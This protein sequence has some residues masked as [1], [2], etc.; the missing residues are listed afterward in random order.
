MNFEIITCDTASPIPVVV[1]VP[2]SSTIIPPDVRQMLCLDDHALQRELLCLTDWFTDRIFDPVLE[3]GGTLFVNRVSR[4]VVDPERFPDDSQEVMA[5]KGMGAVYTHT[6]DGRALRTL[7]VPEERTRLLETYF[8]PYA[9]AFAEL[10]S[11]MLDRHGRCVILDGHSFPSVPLPYERDQ[12]IERP[13]I[14]LGTDDF[15]TPES[16]VAAIRD[17]CAAQGFHV[18]QNRPFAGTY[19]PFRYWQVDP[20]VHS[21]MMEI[22]RDLYM[23]EQTG[24]D[25]PGLSGIR[26]LV[27]SVMRMMGQAYKPGGPSDK[28]L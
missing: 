6:A 9:N 1:H 8:H 7:S 24:A 27:L 22:R 19:V 13:H 5:T 15:H 26:E 10:V 11:Q 21:V 18:A 25:T 28:R 12:R 14:C 17:L 2:H 20:R 3:L 4:L 16:L 23:D